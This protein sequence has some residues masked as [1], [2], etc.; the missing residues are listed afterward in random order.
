MCVHVYMCTCVRVHVYLVHACICVCVCVC[1]R[2]C[3]RACV[4]VPILITMQFPQLFNCVGVMDGC[5]LCTKSVVI[6][7]K[8]DKGD[9][10]LPVC[11]VRGGFYMIENQ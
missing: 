10:V 9:T 11:Y 6:S 7:C 1:A 5:G 8:G 3:V 4:R 2:A